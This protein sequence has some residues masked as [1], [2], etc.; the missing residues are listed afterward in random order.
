MKKHAYLIMVHKQP[1]LLKRLMLLLDDERNDLY[2]HVDKKMSAFNRRQYEALM[3]KS[4][5]FW[6][7]RTNVKWGDYSQINCELLLLKEAIKTE[8]SYYHLLSGMDLPL[9]KQNE[10]HDFF[11]MY[12]GLEFVDEDYES[13]DDSILERI[14][15]YHFLCDKKG[16][17]YQYVKTKIRD[18][19]QNLLGINRIR[20][21]ENVC[22][23]KGRNWFSITHELAVWVVKKEKWIKKVFGNS[24]CGDEMF[25]QT[26]V[27]N[28]AFAKKICNHVTMPEVPDTRYIDWGR[29]EPYVFREYDYLELKNAPGLFARKF[30]IDLDKNI[31]E[32]ICSDLS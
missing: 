9:K 32:K 1:E 10:I 29:G 2:I 31:I 12:N 8:H 24:S 15:Y 6:V 20:K 19:Q 21:Y 30:D 18:I 13:I 3:K 11:E 26:V 23:Q 16:K 28:S 14:R 7:K 17:R 4:A 22:F 25:L 5:V 27:R